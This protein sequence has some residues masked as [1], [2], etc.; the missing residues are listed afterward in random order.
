MIR[1]FT[2][3]EWSHVFVVIGELPS[4]GEV[5]IEAIETGVTINLLS[6]YLDEPTTEFALYKPV[7]DEEHFEK[8]RSAVVALDGKPYGYGQ[9]LGFI[10]TW[11]YYLITGKR[12]KNP[13]SKGII[14][15]ELGLVYL[16]AVEVAPD[17]FGKLDLNSTSPEDLNDII[18]TDKEN[19]ELLLTHKDIGRPTA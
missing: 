10:I 17:V 8:G 1:M 11:P 19:F 2:S 18:D 6:E 4:V 13:W 9:I 12:K 14:C 15:S 7:V 5:I 3:G 16:N